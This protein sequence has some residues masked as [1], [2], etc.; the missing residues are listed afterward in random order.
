MTGVARIWH[1]SHRTPDLNMQIHYYGFTFQFQANPILDASNFSKLLMGNT[2]G[3]QGLKPELISCGLNVNG[4]SCLGSVLVRDRQ[5]RSLTVRQGTPGEYLIEPRKL[6]AGTS[7]VDVNFALIDLATWRGLYSYYHH[8]MS[9]LAYLRYMDRLYRYLTKLELEDILNRGFRTNSEEKALKKRARAQL[10]GGPMIFK[11]SLPELTKRFRKVAT[12]EFEFHTIEFKQ[13]DLVALGHNAKTTRHVFRFGR[14]G[15][16]SPVIGMVANALH[17]L[18]RFAMLRVSGQNEFGLD[19][20][21]SLD[22]VPE[23]LGSQDY[24]Q[25]I[26]EMTLSEKAGPEALKTCGPIR[27]LVE[28][29]SRDRISALL[30][31]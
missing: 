6:E 8:S 23:R 26:E 25:W 22:D 27:R 11:E 17:H 18:D 24:D 10:K 19:Q 16:Q 3:G 31:A 21:I 12:M 2:W 29:A 4:R 15:K 14:N 9:L 30:T 5:A 20:T 1:F 13:Q 28:L 7:M